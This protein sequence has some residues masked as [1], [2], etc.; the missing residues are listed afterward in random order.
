MTPQTNLNLFHR[1]VRVAHAHPE[2]R[3]VLVPI[4]AKEFPNQKALK[5]Y[6]DEHPN[7]DESKHTV[8]DEGGKGK[9]APEEEGDSPIKVNVD[10]E[11]LKKRAPKVESEDLSAYPPDAE[12]DDLAPEHRE[13]I[14]DYKLD[15]VGGDARQAVEIARKIKEGIQKGSDVCKLSPPVCAGNMGLTRDKMPQIEGEKTVKQMLSSDNELDRRKGKAMVQAGADP[16]SDKTILQHMIDH[17]AKNGV[18]TS[19][20]TVPVGA[21][22]ATQSEIKAEKVYG[23]ADAHLKG[24]FNKIDASVVVSRDGYLLDGHHRW[25]ALLTIDPARTMTV[26]VIDMDMEDLLNEAQAVPGVYQANFEG[27]PLDEDKQKAYKEKAK[28]KF[29]QGSLRR[30]A[31]RLAYADPDLRPLL[32]AALQEAG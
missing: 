28:S 3:R 25:A 16:E 31:I 24:K 23:M 12:A 10:K 1:A 19:E 15:I 21:L 11:Q 30:A 29:K 22:K 5:D 27:D 13:E 7:A 20:T 6:L 14:K 9:G 4:L 26:K 2:T 17:L 32:L 18:K 8:K